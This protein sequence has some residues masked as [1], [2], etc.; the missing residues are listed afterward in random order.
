MP[1][2]CVVSEPSIRISAGVRVFGIKIALPYY[3]L[4]FYSELR[5]LIIQSTATV[6]L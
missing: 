1:G 6:L 4:C 2:Y 3:V 5:F